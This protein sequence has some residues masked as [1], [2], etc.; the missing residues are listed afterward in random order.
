MATPRSI[1]KWLHEQ[2]PAW[3]QAGW[4]TPEGAEALR[5]RYD[6]PD[7]SA[8]LLERRLMTAVSVL[9]A[10]LIGGGIILLFAYNWNNLDRPLRAALSFLPLL[11][12]HGLTVFTLSARPRR[13][14]WR[15]GSGIAVT[16]A[17][18]A[19]IALVAQTYNIQG[20]LDGYLLTLLLL[21]APIV[22]VLR[23]RV[24][25]FIL[26]VLLFFWATHHRVE[27]EQLY[28]AWLLFLPVAGLIA[29]LQWRERQEMTVLNLALLLTGTVLLLIAGE[30]RLWH[31]WLLLLTPWFSLGAL[32]GESC[33]E[34]RTG[35]IVAFCAR[36]GLL[37]LLFSAT[38]SG[39]WSGWSRPVPWESVLPEGAV[40][41]VL[42]LFAITAGVRAW[43]GCGLGCRVVSI[44]P[45]AALAAWSLAVLWDSA[46]VAVLVN[47]GVAALGVSLVFRA[48][49]SGQSAGL[50]SGIAI[51]TVLLLLRFFD[52][53]FSLL[54]RGIVFIVCGMAFL[55]FN[56][57]LSRKQIKED[58]K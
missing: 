40:I 23:S 48:W 42:Y 11:V 10:G 37:V 35:R 51:L 7:A 58:A 15:E 45:A 46:G 19:A 47:T 5:R 22:P 38:Y 50:R 12:A 2:L 24:T 56:Y 49:N 57:Q 44:A 8:N 53:D 1:L 41:F 55:A 32:F 21:T 34:H 39:F 18:A 30:Q 52:Y 13:P 27:T 17:V 31:G 29:W 9:G 28:S 4:V 3:E 33:N 36:L 25:A 14:A 26:V 16:A 6:L 43:P 20:D 54:T